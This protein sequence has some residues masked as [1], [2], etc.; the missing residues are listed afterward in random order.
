M[1]AQNQYKLRLCGPIF[2]VTTST[3]GHGR[4]QRQMPQCDKKFQLIM[5]TWSWICLL[6]LILSVTD[7]FFHKSHNFSKNTCL[8][9]LMKISV[10]KRVGHLFTSLQVHCRWLSQTTEV[11]KTTDTE[12]RKNILIP[13]S[14][15]LLHRLLIVQ[16]WKKSRLKYEIKYDKIAQVKI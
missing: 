12:L 16:N 2:V 4:M 10:G 13:F 3:S 6:N 15:Y 14:F 8:A 7:S 11:Q 9:S 1:R 5:I